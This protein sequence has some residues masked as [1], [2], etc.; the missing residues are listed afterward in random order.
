MRPRQCVCLHNA[1]D[2]PLTH[3]GILYLSD[4]EETELASLRKLLCLPK[5]AVAEI[6]TATKGRVF[7]TAVQSALG[8]GIDGFTQVPLT[9]TPAIWHLT[10]D[11][12][13]VHLAGG[14][15]VLGVAWCCGLCCQWERVFGTF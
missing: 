9:L 2:A 11:A 1:I 5:E 6:D 13:H 14:A 15:C 4:E 12:P 8:A 7:R 3:P 10:H